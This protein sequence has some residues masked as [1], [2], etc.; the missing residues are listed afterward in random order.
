MRGLTPRK[1]HNV[2]K[3]LFVTCT[4]LS[5]RN[6][7]GM[8]QGTTEWSSKIFVLCVGA[9]LGVGIAHVNFE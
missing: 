8:S 5:M 6:Y 7:V 1:V 3:N 9:I 4:P 2:A